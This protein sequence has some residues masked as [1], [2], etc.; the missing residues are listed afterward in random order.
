VV[1]SKYLIVS[2]HVLLI[3]SLKHSAGS[4]IIRIVNSLDLE[5]CGIANL[6]GGDTA[7]SV[8]DEGAGLTTLESNIHGVLGGVAPCAET[9]D[10]AFASALG[11]SVGANVL[12]EHLVGILVGAGVG[13]VGEGSA[14]CRVLAAGLSRSSGRVVISLLAHHAIN[15]TSSDASPAPESL[16]VRDLHVITVVLERAGG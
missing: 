4:L 8:N 6:E 1:N 10:R 7:L 14:A 2:I 5:A 12:G 13:R 3:L 15:V 11:R 16:V 9:E